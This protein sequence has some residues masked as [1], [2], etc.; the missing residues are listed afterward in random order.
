MA[1]SLR[2]SSTGHNLCAGQEV[3]A[4]K[5]CLCWWRVSNKAIT[6]AINGTLVAPSNYHDND[7]S[8]WI[9]F[10]NVDGVS[11]HGG[12]L[13]GKGASLWACKHSGGNCPSGATVWFI[14]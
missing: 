8:N 14:L 9:V 13:D 11:V 5:S 10:E 2:L 7:N 3:L 12:L 1:E 6:V 4:R